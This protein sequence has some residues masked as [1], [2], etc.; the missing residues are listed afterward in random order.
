MPVEHDEAYT[1]IELEFKYVHTA[2]EETVRYFGYCQSLVQTVGESHLLGEGADV[3]PWEMAFQDIYA[4]VGDRLIRRL[5]CLWNNAKSFKGSE[6]DFIKQLESDKPRY[7]KNQGSWS[8]EYLVWSVYQKHPTLTEEQKNK[9]VNIYRD[10][11]YVVSSREY[12]D[13]VVLRHKMLAHFA[14]DI[15]PDSEEEQDIL[16]DTGHSYIA[17]WTEKAVKIFSDL[18]ETLEMS[19]TSGQQYSLLMK[20]ILTGMQP[21]IGIYREII[22]EKQRGVLRR[23]SSLP[24]HTNAMMT[25]KI[26]WRAPNGSFYYAE[27]VSPNRWRVYK[28]MTVGGIVAKQVVGEGVTPAEVKTT[29]ELH[30][31]GG[32]D[33]NQVSPLMFEAKSLAEYLRSE[34]EKLPE[35][36]NC[37]LGILQVRAD[38][39]WDCHIGAETPAQILLVAKDIT[40]HEP[41]RSIG[42]SIASLLRNNGVTVAVRIASE[43]EF[44]ETITVPPIMLEPSK[45]R[46]LHQFPFAGELPQN[47]PEKISLAEVP[48]R[49]EAFLV[50]DNP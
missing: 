3:S 40:S 43:S 28:K 17:G 7:S 9:L 41:L 38:I 2:L 44:S 5:V 14:R 4:A 19:G 42:E 16:S 48:L 31:S 22:M 34:T 23:I 36:E 33:A 45:Y 24:S 46:M 1:T 35:A 15:E 26:V 37:V 29:A 47:M 39:N 13:V 8:L 12:A 32:E 21:F 27:K 30:I 18:A 11:W 25:E 49:K 10:I 6:E 20:Q 50:L